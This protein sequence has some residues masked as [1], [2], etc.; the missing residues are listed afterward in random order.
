ML[1]G[2]GV[3]DV[4]GG[5]VWEASL[6]LCAYI[7]MHRKD[8]LGRRVMEMG[9]GIGL[10]SFLLIELNQSVA[11]A[12][13]TSGKEDSIEGHSTGVSSDDLPVVVSM[14]DN[15]VRVLDNLC[16]MIAWKYVPCDKLQRLQHEVTN[17]DGYSARKLPLCN[18]T[19]SDGFLLSGD[20]SASNINDC[21]I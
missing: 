6:L 12:I 19:D 8:F 9:S 4:I 3:M 2:D 10:P 15:D 5:E 16:D 20:Y 13:N 14:T 7:S 11:S 18:A 21:S 1:V 17:S